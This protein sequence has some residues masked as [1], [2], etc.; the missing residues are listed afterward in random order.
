MFPE[1]TPGCDEG[2][3]SAE[4]LGNRDRAAIAQYVYPAKEVLAQC[5]R[6]EGKKANHG[7]HAQSFLKLHHHMSFSNQREHLV[8]SNL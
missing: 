6:V 1:S 4:Q 3:K 7:P 2:M 5:T 8:A